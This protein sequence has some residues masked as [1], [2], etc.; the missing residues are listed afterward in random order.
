MS[1]SRHQAFDQDEKI[2]YEG[3]AIS[4]YAG[5]SSAMEIGAHLGV[6]V[7]DM[8]WLYGIFYIHKIPATGFSIEASASL[9]CVCFH[10]IQHKWQIQQQ[11]ESSFVFSS[12]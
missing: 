5:K 6:F 4:G 12:P 11:Q 7:I 1:L 10:L 3:R 9:P 2:I 8:N